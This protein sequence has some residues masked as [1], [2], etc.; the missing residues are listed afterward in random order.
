M[1]SLWFGTTT[2]M[3]LLALMSGLLTG[4]AASPGAAAPIDGSLV[5]TF[6]PRPGKGP[7]VSPPFRI[8]F[9]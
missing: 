6:K 9:W 1:K 2:L 8:L 4:A 7:E 5:L 3:G